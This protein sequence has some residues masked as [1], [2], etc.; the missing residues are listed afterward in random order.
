MNTEQEIKIDRNVPVPR[1]ISRA[2]YPFGELEVGESFLIPG[3]RTVDISGTI[4][5][6]RVKFRPWK[7]ASRTVEGGVRV[8]RIE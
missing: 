4:G 3:K 8:W 5:L 1:S 2:K 6:A 7:F